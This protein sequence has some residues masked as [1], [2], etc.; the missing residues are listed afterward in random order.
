MKNLFLK[1]T[2]LK[3]KKIFFVGKYCTAGTIYFYFKILYL[4]YFFLAHYNFEVRA[5]FV[6]NTYSQRNLESEIVIFFI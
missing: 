1:D 4:L 3:V 5:M 2:T 6:Y